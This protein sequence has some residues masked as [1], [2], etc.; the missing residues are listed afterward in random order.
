MPRPAAACP[1]PVLSRRHMMQIGTLGLTSFGLADLLRLKAQANPDHDPMP[2]TATIFIWL[3][4]GPP[5][6]ET[7]DMKPLAPAEFRGEFQPIPTNVPGLDVC[8][9][10]PLQAQIADKFNLIRS[11]SHNFGDHG[12]GHKRFMTGRDPRLPV[13]FENDSPAVGSCIAE[14]IKHRHRG[15]PNYVVGTDNGR[16]G[17]D[18]FSLGYS[19]LPATSAPFIFGGDPSAENFKVENLSLLPELEKRLDDRTALLNGLDGLRREI[20]R[21]GIMESVDTSSRRA[22]DLL[23]STRTRDAFDLTKEP[24]EMRERYGMHAYGQRALMARRLVESGVSFVTMMWEN[25]LPG[26]QLPD[27]TIYNW[28]SHA[29]N[30]HIFNDAKV[31]LPLYDQALHALVTDLFDRGLNKKVLLI[32]TGEFGR[33]PKLEYWNG[34]PGRDHWPSAMSILMSGG[35]MRTGQVI[36]STTSKGERPKDRPLTPNDIWATVYKHHGIDISHN[37][38]DHRGRPMPILPYGGPIDELLPVS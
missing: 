17:I 15:I 37:F 29:V 2:D 9:L 28:D 18:V 25:P 38:I 14:L 27:G 19:Y 6:T 24:R 11:C 36:G 22:F 4:G 20:D 3:P 12:G 10:F 16:Q 8:E 23:T 1:G 21:K 34:R 35:G 31:R 33:T 32:V 30:G 5:H 7:Y 13:G 26:K